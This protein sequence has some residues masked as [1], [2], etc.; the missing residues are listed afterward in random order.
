ML[1]ATGV[2][3]ILAI[4]F[5]VITVILFVHN[6]LDGRSDMLNK[7]YVQIT[8]MQEHL[9][10]LLAKAKKV[11][12]KSDKAKKKKKK[13]IIRKLNSILEELADELRF[14]PMIL[15]DYNGPEVADDL[16][17]YY[18]SEIDDEEGDWWK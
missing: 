7:N 10:H 16:D 1:Y 13:K 2:F 17:D 15:E 8:K 5:S 14:E 9:E 18:D 4:D 6:I 11:K 3:F 12:T